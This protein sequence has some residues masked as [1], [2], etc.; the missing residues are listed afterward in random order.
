MYTKE[1]LGTKSLRKNKIY[2]E[3]E[4]GDRY[5]YVGNQAQGDSVY[6]EFA[7]LDKEETLLIREDIVM[8]Q[9]E[10]VND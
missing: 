9:V 6:A 2:A 10:V 8:N 5:K 7:R 4:S 3:K 1:E